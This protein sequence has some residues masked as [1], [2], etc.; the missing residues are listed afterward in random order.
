MGPEDRDYFMLR[1]R[2]ERAAAHHSRGTVRGRH[3]ELASAYDM[4]VMC[5]D[6][7]LTGDAAEASP[8]IVPLQQ[9]IIAA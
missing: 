1:A 7:G 8:E 5:I 3:E 6:R 4:R 9:I 2:Q